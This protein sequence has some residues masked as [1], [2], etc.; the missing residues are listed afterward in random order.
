MGSVLVS[1]PPYNM[2]WTP[3]S[4]SN[5]DK[6]FMGIGVP[7]KNNANYAFILSGLALAH[8]QCFI[9]PSSVLSPKGIEADILKNLIEANTVEAAIALP[10]NMFTATSIATVILV[11]D[12]HK[13]TQKITFV[14]LRE[15][16]EEKERQQNGQFG[17][18]SHVNRTYKKIF[19]TLSDDVIEK[20]VSAVKKGTTEK[21]FC[22]TVDLNTVKQNDYSMDIRR[23]V[24]IDLEEVE[25]RKF[26]EIADDYNRIIKRKNAVKITINETLAKT[27]G[28]YEA[29]SQKDVDISESFAIVDCK[30]EKEDFISF[31]KSAVLKIECRLNNINFP[32]I[33]SIFI[34]MWRQ[35]IMLFNNEENRIL[36]EFRDALLNDLMSGEKRI[37]D[38]N[39][40]K[41]TN[42]GD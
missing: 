40:Y 20:T 18:K 42:H 4:L 28:L 13:K 5:F 27:L 24:E 2:K 16:Y 6:R 29:F 39:I 15:Q 1:N 14:D 31:T 22:K 8:R 25:H 38:E 17:G 19:K 9:L 23:Y 34:T 26:S 37:N 30:A 21:G 10:D 7:P 35:N 36:A 41:W 32:E 11:L 12:K 3:P 33:M